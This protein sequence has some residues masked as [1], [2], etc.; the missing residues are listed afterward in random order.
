MLCGTLAM[1][2]T[3]TLAALTALSIAPQDAPREPTSEE[4]SLVA[5]LAEQ[6]VVLDPVRGFC[7]IPADVLVRDDLLE[8][9]LVGPA[10]AAHES[11]FMTPVSASVLNVALLALGATPGTNASWKAK[12]PLPTE[13]QVRAGVMPYELTLPAGSGFH[14]YV[15]WR[16]DGETYFYRVEDL[17]RN[18]ASGTA[19]KRH[20]WI[21]LGSRMIP[22]GRT[23]AAAGEVFAADTYQNLI[24][25]AFFSEGY[26]LATG[27]LPECM[28]QTIWMLN[29]FLVP[30]RGARV[31]FIFSRTKIGSVTPEVE[32]LLP[33][34]PASAAEPKDR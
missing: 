27:A 2:R 28:D 22:N 21:Y 12:D 1:L 14:L 33:D 32:R 6:N 16:Q 20:E 18:L 24:N 15:G 31:G 19:M 34:L 26:T 7:S 30:E 8:Y 25:L 13:D 3:L 17:I 23:G 10:G 5:R 29:P 9:L 11:V 4:K